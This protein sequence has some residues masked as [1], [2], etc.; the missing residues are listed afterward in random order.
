MHLTR[1]VILSLF[2]RNAA[3]W[4]VLASTAA[5]LAACTSDATQSAA[6]SVT[7]DSGRVLVSS[8]PFALTMEDGEGNV[9]L[10]TLAR[11]EMVGGTAYAPIGFVTG[12]DPE[13]RYPV[14][15][16]LG[17][18]PDPNPPNPVDPSYYTATGVR[19]SSNDG[20]ALVV[21]LETDD[22]Q[23]R[24]IELRVAPDDAGT[25]AVAASVSNAD[26]V[27][28]VFASFASSEGEA[29]HGFG[30]RR[31][32]TDLRG[33]SFQNWVLDYRFPDLATA[34]YYTQP[35]FV[36]SSRYGF[37][38]D[39]D[40]M[41]SWRLASD[42][43]DAWRVIVAGA[44][45]VAVLAPGDPA[46]AIGRITSIT[47]R[48]RVAPSWSIGPML[49]RTYLTGLAPESA[50]SYRAKMEDD[51]A[52]IASRDL[53]VESYAFEGWAAQP[54]DF[55]TE[56]IDGLAEDGL[57]A[58]LYIRSFVSADLPSF[59]PTGLYDEAIEN[60]YVATDEDGEPY[61][62]PS[63]F[64][65]SADAAVID[66][67]NPDAWDWW[68]AQVNEMLELGA[69]GFMNDFGE[70]VDPHMLFLDG[71]TGATMHNRIS[72]L[73][74]EATRE[75]IDDFLVDKPEREIFFFS[76]AGYSGR[77]G[78][79]AYENATFPGDESVDWSPETGLRSIVPDM[80]NRAV[81]GLHGF[82]TNIGGYADWVGPP[83]TTKELYV[84]WS[85]A[86][87]FTAHFRVHG[88]AFNG[89]RMPWFW[90]PDDAEPKAQALWKAA[91]DLHVRARP[92]ILEL[93]QEAADTGMPITR[94]MWL[95]DSEA[96]GNPHNDD[97]WM[98][99]P[100]L[101]AAPVL[102]EGATEREVWLP[103]GCW[104]LHGEGQELDGHA[105]LTVDAPLDVL[106]WFARCGKTPI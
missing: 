24:T 9:V 103:E 71:S 14:L 79:A 36:S 34:Y 88:S 91:A 16:G 100:D 102:E 77:P 97:Q 5:L 45:L 48:H 83:G 53:G 29:F 76:R 55:V 12:D 89:V 19:S 30:G 38:L 8:D 81:G 90:E 85:Q 104:Q 40:A 33:E 82:T 75:A 52:Q 86:A 105:T 101:L 27:S 84:R 106:P 99:G 32:S 23:G 56:V 43:E 6:N 64:N 80:L 41:A 65:A 94:P 57:H 58:V 78:A 68:K 4:V 51:L 63:P 3:T 28:A 95:H 17:A 50:E 7:N 98:L 47:G 35:L 60:G 1:I 22:P 61:L 59:L 72:A 93:W 11:T 10:T 62:F 18:T 42:A 69:D 15:Q 39:T 25:L 21:V 44:E 37:F 87:V 31:E 2:L 26:G 13:L 46:E 49:S 66:F 20:E 73:Q 96:E 74:A 54:R 67:T 92:L 70:Q